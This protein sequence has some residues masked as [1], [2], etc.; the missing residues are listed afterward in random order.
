[1]K[2]QLAL[3]DMSLMDAV[4]LCQEVSELIDI[5]EIG[6]PLLL[7]EGMRSVSVIR[8][9]LPRHEIL[10]DT[11]IVDAGASEA[12]MAFDAGAD[13]C[14]VLGVSDDRTILSTLEV[15][16]ERRGN[17]F[18]DLI[19]VVDIARR[20]KQLEQLGAR[21]L[22]VHTGLDRQAQ[23]I[24]PFAEFQAAKGAATVSTLS[25]A[26][27]INQDTVDPYRQ[28]AADIVVIG[29]AITRA[30]DPLTAALALS[31]VARR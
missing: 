22:A 12:A 30:S 18:V 20:V 3:D 26:G 1:M 8:G 29:S 17:V 15:A 28:A 19:C 2:M 27:G 11:K 9:A 16:N 14:T 25:V 4:R 31:K 13:Y 21:Y 6:T 23:G 24:T 5:V 10:A 7:L